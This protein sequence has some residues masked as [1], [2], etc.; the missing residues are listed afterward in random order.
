MDP[1]YLKRYRG[2]VG[3]DIETT[4]WK[5]SGR[6]TAMTAKPVMMSFATEEKAWVI[7]DEDFEAYKGWL[8]S[9]NHTKVGH[10]VFGFDFPACTNVGITVRGLV[11]TLP[12]SRLLDPSKKAGHGLKEW[13]KRLG[14]EM[15]SF[16]NTLE[17]VWYSKDKS[18]K[19]D[20]VKDGF[21]YYSGV[22]FVEFDY[23][24]KKKHDITEIIAMGGV[25]RERLEH[26][27]RLDAVIALKLYKYL[28]RKLEAVS[29]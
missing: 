15:D 7:Y 17:T 24:R 2:P 14:Y 1:D 28:M 10:N 22:P 8:E 21:N 6:I 29:W 18:Y 23:S 4:G 20:S 27:S 13:G 9:P 5:P 3:F 26:Y 25:Y 11:D 16:N 12:A 19:K